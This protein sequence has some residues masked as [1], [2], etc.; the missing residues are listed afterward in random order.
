MLSPLLNLLRRRYRLPCWLFGAGPWSAQLYRGHQD[1]ARI[2]SLEG[3]HTPLLL[4]P[5]WWLML[6]ALRRSGNS[7]VYVCETAA[8][9]R[10]N[11]IKNLLTLAG[12]EWDRC[13]FLPDEDLAGSEHR[14]DALLRFGRQ[15]PVALQAADYP[16][17]QVNPVPRLNVRQQDRLECDAWIR[18]QAWS[19]GPVVLVQPGNRRSMRQNCWRQ[20][21]VDDKAWSLLNWSALLR[22]VHAS[23]PG[24]Q[25]VLCGSRRELALLRRI[26]DVTG[27]SEVVAV[28]LPLGR[29]LAL[30]EIAHSM[31]SVD[32]GPAHVAAALGSPL[33]V[34]FGDRSPSH[35]LPRSVC[36]APVIGLGGSPGVRHVNEIS[37]QAVFHAWRSLSLGAG[38]LTGIRMARA[39]A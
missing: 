4:G 39:R 15:T 24:V 25:I 33:V 7:P 30:C 26:R 13:V 11:R 34:L 36:G 6:W 16:W 32:T 38:G 22:C 20:H 28:H 23:V 10:L 3:R 2:W 35:W 18:T 8:S 29:L 19:G 12:V 1:I 21:G 5:G 17:Q 27:L 31:I 37:V 14:V 9:E